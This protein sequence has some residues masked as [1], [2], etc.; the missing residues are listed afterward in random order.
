M[1]DEHCVIKDKRPSDQLIAKVPMTSNRLFPLRIV[2]N[3]KGKTNT[4]AAFKEESKETVKF[5]D[6]KENGNTNFQAAFETEVQDES[7]LWHL[8]FEH[9]NFGGMNLL[10]TKNMVK[11]L[12]LINRP[13]RVCEGCI[14]GKQHRETF[15]VRKSYRACTP[16]RLCTLIFVAQCGH[17]P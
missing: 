3:M 11:G 2:P 15:L 9:L 6:K 10:H 8:R 5:L 16:L 14:F 17:H 13:E 1:E 12:P 7:W 4:G